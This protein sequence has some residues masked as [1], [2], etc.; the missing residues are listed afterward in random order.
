[1]TPFVRNRTGSLRLAFVP[2]ALGWLA[3]PVG[4]LVAPA[5]W[6]VWCALGGAAQG[7]GFIVFFSAILAAARTTAE[8]RRL[9]AFMQ[10]GGYALGAL[11]PTVVG[12]LHGTASGA[13]WTPSLVLVLG[14]VVVLV[15]SGAAATGARA[16]S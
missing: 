8:N 7:G 11:G 10:T 9:G 6:P 16:T 5:A 4:L 14:T 15:L 12:A 2:V 1:M 3:L 13:G